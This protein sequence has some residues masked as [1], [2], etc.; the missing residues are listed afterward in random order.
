MGQRFL[1]PIY[2]I[3]CQLPGT[4]IK[5]VC[6]FMAPLSEPNVTDDQCIPAGLDEYS[7]R[8]IFETFHLFF[9]MKLVLFMTMIT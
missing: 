7:F 5:T 1:V 6:V 9:L 2:G 8:I 4:L 3:S